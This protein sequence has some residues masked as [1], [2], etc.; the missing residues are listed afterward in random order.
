[1]PQQHAT[2]QSKN[3][4]HRAQRIV[5]GAAAGACVVD[6][7]DGVRPFS[8]AWWHTVA[9]SAG[10]A[11]ATAATAADVAAAVARLPRSH[12]V[13]VRLVD[14]Y[15]P[16]DV[17]TMCEWRIVVTPRQHDQAEASVSGEEREEEAAREAMEELAAVMDA[18]S[19]HVHSMQLPPV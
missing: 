10:H 15:L 3:D 6:V 1:M 18:L 4:T 2:P 13:C 8:M 11:A 12:K 17:H 19:C 16:G 14:E 7:L 5:R 9:G